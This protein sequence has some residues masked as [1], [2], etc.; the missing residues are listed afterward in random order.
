MHNKKFMKRIILASESPR[1]K[2]ILG[3]TRL[4]FT[5]VPSNYDEKLDDTIDPHILAKR[6]S[7]EKARAVAAGYTDALIISADTFIVFGKKLMGK[8]GTLEEA[9]K[10]LR[11]L[12]G[13]AHSV[14]T[15]YTILDTGTGKKIT[16]SV[17]TKVWIKKMSDDE[18]DAYVAT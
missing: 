3:L 18:L 7:F 1:R 5:V 15:G 9:R 12:N 4:R 17:E 16:R 6:L 2:E 10:M 13:R 14:I 8:P 11:L